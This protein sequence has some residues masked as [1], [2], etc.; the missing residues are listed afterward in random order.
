[1]TMDRLG[2]ILAAIGGFIFLIGT[3]GTDNWRKDEVAMAAGIVVLLAG[4]GLVAY[5]IKTKPRV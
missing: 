2:Y 5:A 4:A 1:M 3:V